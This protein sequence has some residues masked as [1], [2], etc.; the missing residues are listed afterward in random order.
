MTQPV[1]RDSVSQQRERVFHNS[2][3]RQRRQ[4]WNA[5]GRA[6]ISGKQETGEDRRR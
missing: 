4:T 1:G 5:I 6:E 3:P 2:Q